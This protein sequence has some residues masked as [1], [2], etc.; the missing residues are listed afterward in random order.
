MLKLTCVFIYSTI[1]DLLY[2]LLLRL[3][4]L[5]RIGYLIGPEHPLNTISHDV[6]ARANMTVHIALNRIQ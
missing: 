2:L 4:R 5:F 3:T 6:L 1:F